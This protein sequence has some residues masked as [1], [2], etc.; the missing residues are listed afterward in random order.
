MVGKFETE[1][2]KNP[3]FKTSS[4]NTYAFT[5]NLARYNS[6]Q[7]VA[8]RHSTRKVNRNYQGVLELAVPLVVSKGGFAKV[9]SFYGCP[10]L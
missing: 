4:D 7:E 3:T 1:Y 5:Q 10:E 8:M 2:L 6:Q 9:A